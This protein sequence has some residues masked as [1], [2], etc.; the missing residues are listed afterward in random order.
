MRGPGARP[1]AASALVDNGGDQ[2]AFAVVFL[3]AQ[4]VTALVIEIN[5]IPIQR[6]V[7]MILIEL[8]SISILIILQ[9]I[10]PRQRFVRTIILYFNFLPHIV[11]NRDAVILM[12]AVRAVIIR[13]DPISMFIVLICLRRPQLSCLGIVFGLDASALCVICMVRRGDLP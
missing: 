7:G 6:P 9:R 11:V 2:V 1:E 4:V 8:K 3:K 13:P 10:I 5:R 12:I